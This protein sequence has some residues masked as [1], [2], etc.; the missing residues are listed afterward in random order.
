MHPAVI[1]FRSALLQAYSFTFT[2]TIYNRGVTTR[3]FR[4]NKR[5]I[6]VQYTD[7]FIWN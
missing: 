2:R 3:R 5:G 7:N 4:I 6:A 1:V